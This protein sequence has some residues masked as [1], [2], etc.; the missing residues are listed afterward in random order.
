MNFNSG[1]QTKKAE[2]VL[3]AKATLAEGPIWHPTEN[4]LYWVDIEGR[5]LHIFNPET[6]ENKTFDVKERVGTIVPLER[7][8]AVVALQNGIH[9]IDTQT[10]ELSFVAHPIQENDIRFN[11]GKCD[12]AGRF[13]VGT[14]ALDKR[15]GTAVLYRMD[16]DKTIVQML[17]NL[18]ISNGIVW[19]A[20]N[21][22]MYFIDTRSQQVQAFDFDLESGEINNGRV[23]VKIEKSEGSP[24][25]MAIDENDNI[26]IV[27]HGGGAVLNYNPKSGELLQKIT[28]PVP[29]TTACAFGGKNLDTL[30]ITTGT[31][32]LSEKDL[33]KY[34]ASGGIFAVKPGVKGVPAHFCKIKL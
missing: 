9:R 5:K 25:G 7:G 8:G 23:V 30:Y 19:T 31:E 33:K 1:I 34:P 24:D 11:D 14:M 16:L 4:V 27:L 12:A 28:V 26:W 32:G 29:Q 20:D 18:T 21:K 17:D 13:W 15:K 22:T 6:G 3:D 10:G 2:L